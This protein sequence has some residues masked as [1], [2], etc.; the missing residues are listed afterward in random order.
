MENI[1]RRSPRVWGLAHEEYLTEYWAHLME[2]SP[3]NGFMDN[4]SSCPPEYEAHLMENISSCLP[5]YGLITWRTSQGG[6]PSIGLISWRTSQGSCPSTKFISWRTSQGA[7][8][9]TGLISSYSLSSCSLRIL[10]PLPLK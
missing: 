9:S 7:S 6:C 3:S 2:N 1:S 5:E 8:P 10:F 4:I